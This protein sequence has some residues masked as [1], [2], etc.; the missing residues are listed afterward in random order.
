LHNYLSLSKGKNFIYKACFTI[1]LNDYCLK[2][3]MKKKLAILVA[4]EALKDIKISTDAL[5]K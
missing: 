3:R 1:S 4:W 5:S 2:R